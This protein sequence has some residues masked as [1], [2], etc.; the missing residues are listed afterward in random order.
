MLVSPRNKSC[1]NPQ[2]NLPRR[3]KSLA[4]SCARGSSYG[5]PCTVAPFG[6]GCLPSKPA[7]HWTWESWQWRKHNTFRSSNELEQKLSWWYYFRTAL[8]IYSG[9]G[10]IVELVMVIPGRLFT[11]ILTWPTLSR[12]SR[13]CAPFSK[14]LCSC[15]LGPFLVAWSY[16]DN[17]GPKKNEKLR[18][19][20]SGRKRPERSWP[21]NALV[22]FGH[23]SGF[24]QSRHLTSQKEAFVFLPVVDLY[25]Y[26]MHIWMQS[27]VK[28]ILYLLIV[29][30][31]YV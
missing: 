28:I 18:V 9:N 4:F 2:L 24:I 13:V 14:G 11:S 20:R 8:V 27:S 3:C 26:N 23:R 22:I 25:H 31:R 1:R 15:L 19:E 6:D 10:N 21:L 5:C 7:K 30:Q 17:L 29:L 16:R 12:K